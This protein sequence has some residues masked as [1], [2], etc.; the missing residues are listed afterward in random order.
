MMLYTFLWLLLFYRL[1]LL[2]YRL[3]KMALYFVQTLIFMPTCF[4]MLNDN[5]SQ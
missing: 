1:L 3:D 4:M 5:G 2:L